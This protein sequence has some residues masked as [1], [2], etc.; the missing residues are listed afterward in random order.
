MSDDSQGGSNRSSDSGLP[1]AAY[2][3]EYIDS[4]SGNPSYRSV[5]IRKPK[6]NTKK[7][8]NLKISKLTKVSDAEQAIREREEQLRREI[9]D[10]ISE[11]CYGEM[12]KL[13]SQIK[14]EDGKDTQSVKDLS[15]LERRIDKKF[16]EL[17]DELEGEGSE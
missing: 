1:V 11:A 16:E 12:M 15:Q 3:R 4:H 8:Y 10:K 2:L 5:S 7:P 13:K 9:L 17:C 6:T 14:E